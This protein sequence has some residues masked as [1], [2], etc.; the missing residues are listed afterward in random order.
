MPRSVFVATLTT[1]VGAAAVLA[2]FLVSTVTVNVDVSENII[3]DS[4]SVIELTLFP[5]ET[6]E[7]EVV[8]RNI[9]SVA[10]AVSITAELTSGGNGID[11]TVPGITVVPADGLQHTFIVTLETEGDVE[12]AMHTVAIE[13]KRD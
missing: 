8:L 11:I 1:T 4:P 3:L 12:P 10:Q 13:I 7:I 6:Q 9:G 2:A 5:S